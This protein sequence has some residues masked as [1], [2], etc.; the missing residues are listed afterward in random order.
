MGW[1][2]LDLGK[3][4]YEFHNPPANPEPDD[5]DDNNNNAPSAAA[6]ENQP[7]QDQQQQQQQEQQQQQ[8]PKQPA[9]AAEATKPDAPEEAKT[10]KEKVEAAAAQKNP[11]VPKEL[12]E[13]RHVFF[14]ALFPCPFLWL[15][16][17]KNKDHEE[18]DASKPVPVKS[19]LKNLKPS[20]NRYSFREEL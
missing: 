4:H 8:D 20:Q 16:L 14:V 10:L 9:A 5:D 13:V 11:V 6:Q 12:H 2:G 15:L 3:L 7:Q 1:V 17:L 19:V 18:D